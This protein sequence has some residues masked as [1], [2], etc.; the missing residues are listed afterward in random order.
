MTP[1]RCQPLPVT[2]VGPERIVL[3]DA[4]Q[5]FLLRTRGALMVQ[6]QL[7]FPPTYTPPAKNAYP[8]YPGTVVSRDGGTHWELWK[9]LPGQGVGP[10]TEGA[11]AELRDGTFLLLDWVADGPSPEGVFSGTLWRSTDGLRTFEG[12]IMTRIRVPLA[13]GG[14]T[15]DGGVPT[16]GFMLHRSMLEL[17]SGVLLASAYCWFAGDRV[18]CPYQP[19][20]WKFRCIVIASTD[21]GSSWDYLATIAADPDLGEEGI[22]EPV[23]LRLARGP[24][25]GRLICL[26]RSGCCDHAVWQCTSDDEGNTWSQPAA[27]PFTGVDPDLAEMSDGTLA[28]ACGRRTAK[29]W[30]EGQPDPR[31]GN[32][33]LFSRDQGESWSAP[34]TLPIESYATV[35]TTTNYM[36]VCETEPGKLL[37]LYDV[38]HWQLPVRYIASRTVL[39]SEP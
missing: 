21:R 9:P 18:P 20:M 33:L 17:P 32:H 14:S 27:L 2:A 24:R 1:A 30:R 10:L 15:D 38:G 31:H 36:S 28:C 37:V 25:A 29:R 12:P 16:S 6:G 4:L 11:G 34:L 7:R 39:L 23:I 22:N 35:G 19:S 5:P 8:G 26:M 3:T 13:V